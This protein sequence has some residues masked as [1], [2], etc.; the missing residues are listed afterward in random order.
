MAL[1]ISTSFTQK[2]KKKKEKRNINIQ[3]ILKISFQTSNPH[4]AF[5]LY[6]LLPSQEVNISFFFLSDYNI[7]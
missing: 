5:H 2:K 7:S 1:E 4:I 6:S 3:L